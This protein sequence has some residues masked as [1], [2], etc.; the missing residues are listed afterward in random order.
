MHIMKN[1]IILWI[2]W[3]TEHPIV[4]AN[5]GGGIPTLALNI[6]LTSRVRDYID[7]GNVGHS[8]IQ[9]DKRLYE[10]S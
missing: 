4:F 5:K 10:H 8:L 6:S 2:K 7:Q 3:I 9:V 1:G